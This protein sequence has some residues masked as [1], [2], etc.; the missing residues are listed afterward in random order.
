M[1]EYTDNLNSLKPGEC[2]VVTNL[3]NKGNIRR[4]L[5]ELGFA[6]GSK[7]A[8][9][10]IAPFGDPKAYLIKN[11]VIALREEDSALI[12]IIKENSEK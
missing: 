8:C 3:E 7:T 9:L 11:T 10:G 12:K 1:S 2:A 5:M 4:R 6:K